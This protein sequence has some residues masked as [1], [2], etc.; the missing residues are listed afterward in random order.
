MNKYN[1][2]VCFNFK[3]NRDS[4]LY[5]KI[6]AAGVPF[7]FSYLINNWDELI[8]YM[9]IGVS[10][11][12]I[13]GFLGF[14]LDKVSKIT[15]ERKVQ[16]RCYCNMCQSVWNEGNSFK[17]F[18]I[19]PEDMY[20]Y[21]EY[22]DIIEFFKSEDTQNVLYDV[23]FH[24]HKWVGNLQEIVKGLKEPVNNYYIL[25]SD[26]A[27]RRIKCGKKCLKGSNCELCERIKELADTLEN[28]DEY[29]VFE[30]KVK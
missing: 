29:E 30:R 3:Y 21:D 25:G 13:T 20:I 26:F 19:R 12:F 7:Y 15:K 10:D 6:K 14:E 18:F 11:V 17:K 4:I 2:A 24:T 1:I 9:D 22:I 27:Q 16:L 5:K 28:S 23:Y 8:G